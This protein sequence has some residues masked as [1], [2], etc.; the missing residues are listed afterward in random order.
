M[1]LITVKVW[2][3]AV[4][5]FC[6]LSLSPQ[7]VAA[8][9]K[10]EAL[11]DAATLELTYF[12]FDTA[13]GLFVDLQGQIET[14]GSEL[15]LK[16]TLGRA[17]S[18]HNKTPATRQALDEAWGEYESLVV[19][20]P[21]S[22]FAARALIQLG[23][24]AEVRDYGGDEID[25][26]AARAYYRQVTEGW[27]DASIAD[28]AA[29]RYADTY[30]Q[31][32]DEPAVVAQ[33]VQYLEDWAKGRDEQPLAS[34]IWEVI[35]TVKGDQLEDSQG[36]LN[37]YLKVESLG[38][39]EPNSAGTLYYRAA[40]LAEREV[41]D[42]PTAIR[43]YQKVIT[44][45]PRSGRAFNAQLALEALRVSHPAMDIDIPEIKMFIADD[46]NDS[47]ETDSSATGATP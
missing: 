34:V 29:L 20:A 40:R 28:E 1:R 31:R 30:F 11:F 17:L 4:L 3:L 44:E 24:V 9:D 35:A 18:A 43:L 26:D 41:G 10:T 46:E 27:P 38:L 23:R 13:H 12:N 32:F 15:W 42:T 14:T 22:I 25:L 33:G 36:A 21:E 5:F 6:F 2:N 19:A 7:P 45:A 47:A 16:A 39:A 8:Q 37:A